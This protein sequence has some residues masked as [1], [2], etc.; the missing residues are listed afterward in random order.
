MVLAK[1]FAENRYLAV[2]DPELRHDASVHVPSP[3]GRFVVNARHK[4][5]EKTRVA[6]AWERVSGVPLEVDPTRYEGPMVEKSDANATHDGRV[7]QGPIG[8]EAVA[9][10]KVYQRLIDNTDGDEVIDLRVPLLDGS[11]P[12][13]YVKRR[14]LACRFS[15]QNA[16]VVIREPDEVF[17]IDEQSRLARFADAMGLDFCE[18][19]VLR[20]NASGMIWAVDITNGPAG[21]R[22]GPPNGLPKDEARRAVVRLARTFDEMIERVA[23]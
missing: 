9:A 22:P 13:L 16:S 18:V 10:R 11:I 7:V 14:A 3:A 19:D 2:L 4:G 12:L 8:P 21:P 23:T 20:D 15:N 5:N 6:R 1:I 17:S